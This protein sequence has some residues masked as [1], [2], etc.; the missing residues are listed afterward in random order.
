MWT[1]DDKG[2]KKRSVSLYW[3]WKLNCLPCCQNVAVYCK[4]VL[5]NKASPLDMLVIACHR[6]SD[7]LSEQPI[8]QVSEFPM[9]VKIQVT[10]HRSQYTGHRATD[11]ETALKVSPSPNLFTKCS[12]RPRGGCV[13]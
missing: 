13:A 6:N 9:G 1:A 11:N 5:W 7:L 4:V 3:D 10:F 8:Q 12:F 2:R